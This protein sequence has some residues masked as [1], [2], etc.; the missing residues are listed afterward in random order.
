[1]SVA[2]T[3]APMRPTLACLAL[4]IG[5]CLPHIPMHTTEHLSIGWR[6]DYDRA[7]VEAKATGRPIL[8]VMASGEKNGATCPGADFLRSDALRSRKVVDLVNLAF[9]PVWINVRTT[10][11]PPFPFL[12]EILVTARLNAERRV[13]D[14]WSRTFYVHTIIASFDGQHLLNR[15]A[16][17]VASTARALL[18]EGNFSY[19]AIDAGGYLGILQRA[20]ERQN[21]LRQAQ[22]RR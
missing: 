4:L 17:T 22:A 10:P 2:E 21:D 13:V 1:M 6:A 7:L 3:L 12:Q 20:L 14:R 16:N 9:V 5:G 8:V 11:L 15:G 18:L 19:E